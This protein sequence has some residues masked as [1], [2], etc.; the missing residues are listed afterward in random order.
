M[1][2]I[3]T[4][5]SSFVIEY[6]SRN[7]RGT[8]ATEI[9]QAAQD[10]FSQSAAALRELVAPD[11]VSRGSKGV[12]KELAAHSLWSGAALALS[13][14]AHG[15]WEP[16]MIGLPA[17]TFIAVAFPT[18]LAWKGD[19]HMGTRLTRPVAVA[20]GLAAAAG[21]GL[22]NPHVGGRGLALGAAG[23]VALLQL[24]AT[25]ASKHLNR[26]PQAALNCLKAL[27]QPR[28]ELPDPSREEIL[29]ALQSLENS[30]RW[31]RSLERFS[32]KFASAQSAT[33]SQLLESSSRGPFGVPGYLRQVAPEI[34][35]HTSATR[36]V[37]E[38]M[39]PGETSSIELEA[40]AVKVGDFTLFLED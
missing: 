40:D 11:I 39:K 24:V 7:F 19:I 21:L 17:A 35:R 27:E 9:H 15:M 25:E 26:R 13:L 8:T 37:R 28:T 12:W 5:D 38:S 23:A 10:R 22:F 32:D 6:I 33:L 4:L 18:G 3:E 30:G 36:E 20:S 14:A 29:E 31:T 1:V 16:T 34:V 2:H